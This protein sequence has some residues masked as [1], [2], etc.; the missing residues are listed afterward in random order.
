MEQLL[1]E[2]LEKAKTD[3]KSLKMLKET[4][5]RCQQFELASQLR[6]LETTIFPETD[7]EKEAK[8]IN[9]ALRMVDLNVSNDVCWLINETL[10][11]Y[12]KMK[13]KFSAKDAAQLMAKRKELFD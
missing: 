6:E 11:T 2:L 3:K 10:K 12:S 1:N 5:V 13:G 4:A 9:V 8:N 7:E